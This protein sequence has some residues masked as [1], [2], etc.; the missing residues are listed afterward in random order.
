MKYA[1]SPHAVEKHQR[2]VNARAEIR[3]LELQQC[4]ALREAALGFSGAVDRLRSIDERIAV[5]R[6]DLKVT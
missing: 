4:R 6:S 5:L 1:L 2:R 3:M